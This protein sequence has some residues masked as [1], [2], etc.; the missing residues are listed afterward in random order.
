MG[1]SFI[2]K[3]K[4]LNVEGSWFYRL[5]HINHELRLFG[6]SLDTVIEI[7]C[8]RKYIYIDVVDDEKE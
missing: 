6:L 4:L 1:M 2:K 3:I 7:R 8:D 5:A